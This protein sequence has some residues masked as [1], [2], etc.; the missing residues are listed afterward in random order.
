[1]EEVFFTMRDLV[2]LCKRRSRF[3]AKTALW[4]FIGAFCVLWLQKPLYRADAIFKQSES[5]QDQTEW[6]RSFLRNVGSF[7]SDAGGQVVMQSRSIL[8]KVIEDLGLQMQVKERGFLGSCAFRMA[9][10]LLAELGIHLSPQDRF[11]FRHVVFEGAAS[12][13]FFLRYEGEGLFSVLDLDKH[14]IVQAPLG[15]VFSLGFCSFVL[16][17]VPS[18]MKIG[19]LYRVDVRPWTDLWKRAKKRLKIKVS[20]IDKKALLLSYQDEHPKRAAEFL[21]HLMASYQAYL[22]EENE[23]VA[24]AQIEYLRERQQELTTHY[25]KALEEHEAY[26]VRSLGEDGVISLQQEIEVLEKPKEEYLSKLLE[27]EL[28]L[29]RLYRVSKEKNGISFGEKEQEKRNLPDIASQGLLAVSFLQK[30]ESNTMQG[31]DPATVQTLLIDYQGQLDLL[32]QDIHKLSYLQARI[33]DPDFELSSLSALLTDPVSQN[34]IQ[35]ASQVTFDLKDAVNHSPKDLD[36]LKE[37]LKTQKTFLEHH[38][39]QTV[40]VLQEQSR[41]IEQKIAALQ[42]SLLRI[43]EQEKGLI[44]ERLHAMSD[45]MQALPE[46]WK[47][48]NRL[49]L[50]RDLSIGMIEGLTRL[51][52]SKNVD[53]RLF[54][55]ESKPID[56]AIVPKEPISPL[57][58]ILS[59]LIAIA[60][61]L[62]LYVKDVW[63]WVSEG[64]PLSMELFQFHGIQSPGVLKQDLDCSW[65]EIGGQDQEVMRSLVQWIISKKGAQVFS[66]VG[67][68]DSHLARHMAHL[69][70][71]RGKK[72]LVIECC[73]GSVVAK[74][75]L[76]DYLKGELP[77]IPI[78]KQKE[79]DWVFSGKYTPYAVEMLG[80]ERFSQF[81]K[82]MR[83]CYDYLILSA[84][85]PIDSSSA[86]IHLSWTDC[87]IAYAEQG[88]SMAYLEPYLQ[89][90]NE[91]FSV[92]LSQREL[93]W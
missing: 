56:W 50:Q 38:V 12:R 52:E 26:L 58:L 57:L 3:Y 54:T 14:V 21:N 15:G 2:R 87:C 42:H 72:V 9:H 55:V 46:K 25:E 18:S 64:S 71:V 35:K 73:A 29:S 63:K 78:V 62:L 77:E 92:V 53:S 82:E 11:F 24:Q 37:S 22:K 5:R 32:E 8:K 1:M 65:L 31:I 47:M 43:L 76:H 81:I 13:S 90:C 16:E 7:S 67:E 20:K 83:S 86:S 28:G 51:A 10:N 89:W 41:R 60:G 66:I 59:G 44:E 30:Q 39:A 33:I 36:R 4:V 70:V 45:R 74:Q 27:V 93:R 84:K 48:E 34:M 49:A 23:E 40:E 68:I 79:Y 19:K 88:A 61:V 75:G 80:R 17:Q 69:L 91:R 6:V 85:A